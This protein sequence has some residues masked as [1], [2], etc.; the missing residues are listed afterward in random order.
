MK[1]KLATELAEN[2]KNDALQAGIDNN[3]V[4]MHFNSALYAWVADQVAVT[5]PRVT[6]TPPPGQ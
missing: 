4:K 6:P 1:G 5:A 3:T 2:W